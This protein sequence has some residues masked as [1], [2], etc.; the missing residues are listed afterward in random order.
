MIQRMPRHSRIIHPAPRRVSTGPGVQ[1]RVLAVLGAAAL[2]LVSGCVYR[3]AVQQGNY[4]DEKQLEQL[5]TGMTRA[6]VRFLLGTPML[7][8]A[9]DSSRWDYV[10]YLKVGRLQKADQRRLSVFFADDKV[11]RVERSGFPAASPPT[12]VPPAAGPDAASP[13]PAPPPAQS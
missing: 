12:D 6:Q 13:Q 4:L 7:P 9:F 10:Y 5:Q 1:R 8:D 11:A 2:L 3:V